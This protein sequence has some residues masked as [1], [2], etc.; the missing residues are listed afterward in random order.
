MRFQSFLA[1]FH[2]GAATG[3]DIFII[4]VSL[5]AIFIYSFVL[6]K[7]RMILILLSSYF[8]LTIMKFLPWD[9]LASISWLGI[10]QSPAPSLKILIFLALILFFFIFIPRSVLSSA[11]RIRKRGDASWIQLSILGILQVGLFVSIL[12]SFLPEE[13][14]AEFTPVIDKIFLG[15]GAQFIWIALPL[16]AITLM[17]KQK[18]HED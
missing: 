9:R 4:L 17:K 13:A 16:F 6:G 7:N 5:I 3:W 1:S 14:T 2:I 8:S 15:Q 11:L 10:G 12:L 18:K